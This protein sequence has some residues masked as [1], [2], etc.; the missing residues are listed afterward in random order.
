[1]QTTLP[2]TL[3][4]ETRCSSRHQS[5]FRRGSH[6]P[7]RA[8]QPSDSRKAQ[9]Q[10]RGF[11]S[12][13]ASSHGAVLRRT[14]VEEVQFAGREDQSGAAATS[15]DVDVHAHGYSSL[16]LHYSTGWTQPTMLFS[17]QGG[18]W[19][20]RSL[21][22]VASSS[23][24]WT[25]TTFRLE[26]TAPSSKP[27]LEF[28]LTNGMMWDKKINGSNYVIEEAGAFMLQDGVIEAVPGEK[29][30][31][32]SDLDDTM[33]GDDNGTAAFKRFW[34][35]EAVP[36]GSRLVY[37]TGRALE[38]CQQLFHEKRDVLPVP[39]YLITS[40]GTQVYR[41]SNGGWE[42]DP[43]HTA[44]L[45]HGWD[46]QAV[47][48]AAYEALA[49]VGPQ[50]FHFRDRTEQNDYKVTCGVAVD[51][52]AEVLD[53]IETSLEVGG[54]KAKT[55]ISGTGDWR[56][57]DIVSAQAGK[58]AAMEGLRSQL[59][60][61]HDATVACGDSGNDIDM[62][63]GRNRGI[64]VGN[65]QRELLEWLVEQRGRSDHD[66]SRLL[67]TD[68]NRAYGILEGLAHYGFLT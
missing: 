61:S 16:T 5:S 4:A 10:Q 48:D 39:D 9:G 21:D 25:S 26:D 44:R 33:I 6:I 35:Q 3:A 52:V 22:E 47:R 51:A 28:V 15:P 68:R 2:R 30:L 50:R 57:L 64:V 38:K 20:E 1:M 46:L 53:H 54:V 12:P 14:P 29:V 40:V 23:G 62:F 19:Q 41:W 63:R 31:L 17:L 66:R 34:Q 67:L 49:L 37:N 65:A 42:E 56:F 24:K 27:L 58:H 60:F 13:N 59:G 8:Q 32:V 45:A 55:I 7:T 43:D 36:R 18:D 11:T